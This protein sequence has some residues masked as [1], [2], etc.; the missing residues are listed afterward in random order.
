MSNLTPWESDPIAKEAPPWASDPIVTP[1]AETTALGVAGQFAGGFNRAM[2]DI[3]TGPERFGEALM[4]PLVDA[5]FEALGFAPV[6]NKRRL[7]SPS[8]ALGDW[9]YSANPGDPKTRPERFARRAGE[10]VGESVPYAAVP[11]AGAMARVPQAAQSQTAVSLGLRAM[12]EGIRNTPIRA[13]V[14]EAIAAT[15]AGIGSQTAREINP[16]NPTLDV[17]LSLAGGMAPSALAYTPAALAS[18]GVD[19]AARRISPSAQRRAAREQ[20]S[21]VLGDEINPQAEASL[22]EADRL[23]E[24][25]PGFDPTLAEVTGSPSLVATQ[26]QLEGQASGPALEALNARRAGNTQAIRSYADRVAPSGFGEPEFV[27]DT[28]SR[29]VN[30]LRGAIDRER[31]DLDTVARTQADTL[32]NVNPA[33]EGRGLRNALLD[34]RDEA[35]VR[36]ARL[37][38]QLGINDADI[39]VSFRK[40][41]EDIADE[42]RPTSAFEDASNRPKVLDDILSYGKRSDDATRSLLRDL[43]SGG[44]KPKSLFQFLRS[45]GGIQ[46]QGGEL[47]DRKSVV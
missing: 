42:F 44:P 16:D 7:W 4:G 33:Q 31:T 18:R 22:R 43:R 24:Q 41:Q 26:R 32:P 6:E 17:A 46:D 30:D 14:G 36:M 10:V 45:K 29:R 35:K 40:A 23:R 27:V 2:G 39:T 12:G 25:M 13:G 8:Q 34:R 5:G 38:D 20:V 37:A 11:F 1:T 19:F 47:A 21:T 9:L 3:V 15:G 28:A